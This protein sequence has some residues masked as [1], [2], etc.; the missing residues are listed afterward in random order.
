[1]QVLNSLKSYFAQMREALDYM[2]KYQGMYKR[3]IREVKKRENDRYVFKAKDKT[4][5]MWKLINGKIGKVQ[6]N[7]L[8]LELRIEKIIITNPT[9]I[10]EKLNSYFTSNVKDLTKQMNNVGIYNSSQHVISH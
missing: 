9:E 10:D 5:A 6:L 2:K 3:V 8:R 1:M 4:K 7:Y